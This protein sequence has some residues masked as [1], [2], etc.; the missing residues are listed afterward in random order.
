MWVPQVSRPRKTAVQPLRCRTSRASHSRIRQRLALDRNRN[1]PRPGVEAQEACE[2][3]T[4]VLEA[5]HKQRVG[6]HREKTSNKNKPNSQ[7]RPSTPSNPEVH[8]IHCRGRKQFGHFRERGGHGYVKS[9]VTKSDRRVA[10]VVG[11]NSNG[12]DNG[13]TQ[14]LVFV[15]LDVPAVLSRIS[16]LGRREVF[17]GLIHMVPDLGA[18]DP[19]TCFA[20]S[21]L[22]DD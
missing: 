21:K 2:N 10:L 7:R 1:P 16:L 8:Q 14:R 4:R 9:T 6:I 17:H 20:N 18:M 11:R 22:W 13:L 15:N 3:W 5:L 19:R 12:T